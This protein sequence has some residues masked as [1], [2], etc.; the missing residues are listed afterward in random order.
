MAANGSASVLTPT[1]SP[2]ARTIT[3]VRAIRRAWAPDPISH[4]GAIHAI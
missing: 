1:R 4:P 3:L 2:L